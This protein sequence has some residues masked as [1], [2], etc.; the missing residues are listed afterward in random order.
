MVTLDKEWKGLVNAR[1]QITGGRMGAIP[2]LSWAGLR[3][4]WAALPSP[5][6]TASIQIQPHQ[7]GRETFSGQWESTDRR[8]FASAG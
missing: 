7:L 5:S 3:D 8:L 1:G 4:Q 6:Y 2:F